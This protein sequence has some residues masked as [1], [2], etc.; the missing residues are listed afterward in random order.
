LEQNNPILILRFEGPLQSWGER[1]R[2][3][4]R[5]TAFM[6]T[7]SGVVGLIACAM[8]LPRGD[9][10][11]AALSDSIAMA[12]RADRPGMLMTDYH[13]VTGMI[14]TAEGK[15]RGKVGEPSTIQS[16]R[17]YLQDASFL[18]A[19][20]ADEAT[21]FRCTDALADPVWP[22][23]LGRKCC[24]PSRPVSEGITKEY[25][26]LEDVMQRYPLPARHSAAAVMFEIDSPKNGYLKQDVLTNALGHIY[27][28][29]RVELRAKAKE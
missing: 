18:V 20:A 15:K 28:H 9:A 13:T 3:D 2:W 21:L 14:R 4:Q 29:R 23:W 24:V 10:K 26:S 7:K 25:A 5:D 1:S 11:I 6:P 16:W 12:V 17:Q 22:V 19:V 27:K 8:G